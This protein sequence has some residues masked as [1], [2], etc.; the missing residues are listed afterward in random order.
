VGELLL[1]S[2]VTIKVMSDSAATAARAIVDLTPL[3]VREV[4]ADT[5]YSVEGIDTP[6]NSILHLLAARSRHG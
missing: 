2:S 6:E 1:V 4:A 3:V 5:R